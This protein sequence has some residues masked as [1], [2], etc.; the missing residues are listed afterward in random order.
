MMGNGDVNFILDAGLWQRDLVVWVDGMIFRNRDPRWKKV[1]WVAEDEE[2]EAAKHHAN[3]VRM[4]RVNKA[5]L[6]K[7]QIVPQLQHLPS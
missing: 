7:W 6:A 3:L 2:G 4:R 1:C 5:A